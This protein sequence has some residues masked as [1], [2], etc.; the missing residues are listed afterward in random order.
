MFGLINSMFI[1]V[2]FG[3]VIDVVLCPS[4]DKGARVEMEGGCPRA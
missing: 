4:T 2:E 3:M 1:L